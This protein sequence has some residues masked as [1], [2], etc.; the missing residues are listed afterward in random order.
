MS[1]KAL[2]KPT[3]LIAILG[4]VPGAVFFGVSVRLVPLVRYQT[5]A[6]TLE[7]LEANSCGR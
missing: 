6:P 3:I 7:K 1:I 2:N 5:V 4:A